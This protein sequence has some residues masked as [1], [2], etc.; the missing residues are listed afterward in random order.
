M[1]P[2]NAFKIAHLYAIYI[3]IITLYLITMRK[4]TKKDTCIFTPISLQYNGIIIRTNHWFILLS[5]GPT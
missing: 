3:H 1:E 5:H 2:I 4:V